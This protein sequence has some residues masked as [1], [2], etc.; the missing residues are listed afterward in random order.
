MLDGIDLR[1]RFAY[2]NG[3]SNDEVSSIG[4]R[5]S[6][7]VL[8]MMVAL[9]IKGDERIL[10]DYE[11]GE[12]ADFI[13]MSMLRSLELDGMVNDV[14]DNE[15]VSSVVEDMLDREYCPNGKG[16]L[17][18][19]DSPRKDMRDVDIWYQMNW[20]IQQILE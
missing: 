9:S 16:G 1:Y 5:N 2:E 15:R 17:F 12:K 8:E 7:S 11:T 20:Y 19:V 6:C 3:Y 13:F 10:Y 18:T 14:F 4:Y